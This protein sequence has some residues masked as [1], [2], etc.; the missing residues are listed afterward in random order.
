[1]QPESGPSG[2]RPD[3]LDE[4][5]RVPPEVVAA[6]RAG[7]RIA[8]AGHVTPDADC[9]G[10][11]G[12]L[13]LALPELG[14]P[15]H[16][17][18]PAGTVSRRLE[19]LVRHAG[20]KPASEA[21]LRRCD[22]W[23]V[24]DTAKERRVSLDG[25]L[26]TPSAA[27]VNIDHHATNTQFGRWNW[28]EAERSSTCEMVHDLIVALGCQL[29]PT[30]A[31]LLYAGIHTDTKGFSLSNTTPR[32][33]ARAARLASAGARIPELCERLQ[34]SHS[35]GEFALLQC[36]FAN[37][38]VSPDGRL[39]WSTAS[40][41][42]IE[43][44]GCGPSDIDDQVDIPR[45]IEGIRIA[46]LFSEAVPGK[47]RMNFRGEGGRDA[48]GHGGTDVLGLARTFGGGGHRTSAGAML[49][50]ALDEVVA[51]VIP[52]AI[53]YVGQLPE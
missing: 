34:R 8:L 12:A 22:L 43:A 47:V 18:L 49:D 25:K 15:A 35:R 51:R 44:A 23:L 37:T 28:V 26:E 38:H 50:G 41:G 39:A 30:V 16:V 36:V 31:T 19:Y 33:L 29:N 46:I 1:M 5:S 3:L 10:A 42:E 9:L 6:I 4:G 32:S 53:Q 24:L 11:M 14:K 45:S 21:E 2:A 7:T 13:H 20:L 17:A 40:A 48:D 27:I 52:S